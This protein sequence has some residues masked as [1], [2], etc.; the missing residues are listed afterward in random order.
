MSFIHLYHVICRVFPPLLFLI[1]ISYQKHYQ[2]MTIIGFVTD[3]SYRSIICVLQKNRY[4]REP[5]LGYNISTFLQH[6]YHITPVC[7]VCQ[8]HVPTVGKQ[9]RCHFHA[10]GWPNF[11]SNFTIKNLKKWLIRRVSYHRSYRSARH[12]LLRQRPPV[13]E[14]T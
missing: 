13:L 6:K 8:L 7:S 5:L 10:L 3:I 12:F 4:V 11:D 2:K 9:G 1:G 14:H